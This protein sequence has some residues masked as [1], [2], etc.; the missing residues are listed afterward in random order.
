MEF[1]QL[2]VIYVL[3]RGVSATNITDSL[4]VFILLFGNFRY[5]MQLH[6]GFHRQ[7]IHIGEAYCSEI[8]PVGAEFLDYKF[9][10]HVLTTIILEEC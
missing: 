2:V 9:N 8:K 3:C 5:K 1:A 10:M 7:E 4:G 6:S